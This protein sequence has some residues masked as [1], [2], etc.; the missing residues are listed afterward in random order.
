MPVPDGAYKKFKVMGKE[1]DPPSPTPTSSQLR[2]QQGGL[3]VDAASSPA[4]PA[5]LSVLM[6]ACCWR[7]APGHAAAGAGGRAGAGA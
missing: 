1:F 5:L 3:M 7:V 6:L 2:D 4:R